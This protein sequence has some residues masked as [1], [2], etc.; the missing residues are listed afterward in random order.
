MFKKSQSAYA[1]EQVLSK[2]S[3]DAANIQE[4]NSIDY[5]NLFA[6][7][8]KVRIFERTP[9]VRNSCKKSARDQKRWEISK[10]D[11]YRFDS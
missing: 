8:W 11:L 1:T 10:N 6:T 9:A 4:L 2:H 7:I 5:F 3:T